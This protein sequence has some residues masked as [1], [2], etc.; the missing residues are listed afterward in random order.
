MTS[1]TTSGQ[2]SP[3]TAS[4]ITVYIPSKKLLIPSK[5]NPYCTIN[6]SKPAFSGCIKGKSSHFGQF[7]NQ[8]KSFKRSSRL[9]GLYRGFAYR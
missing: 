3:T 1:I 8:E 6:Q 7:I 5:N 4:F 2:G 9:S